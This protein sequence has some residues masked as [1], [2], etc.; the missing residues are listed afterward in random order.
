M[1]FELS[2]IPI[3]AGT[4]IIEQ[5]QWAVE[6]NGVFQRANFIAGIKKRNP[7]IA[8]MLLLWESKKWK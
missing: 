4:K 2:L 1:L 6:E 7:D 5:D 3:A 8:G